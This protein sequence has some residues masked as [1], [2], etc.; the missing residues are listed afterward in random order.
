MPAAAI[1]LQRISKIGKSVSLPLPNTVTQIG[2]AYK[3]LFQPL[4][5]LLHVQRVSFWPRRLPFSVCSRPH[6]NLIPPP[7]LRH[8]QGC[9]LF[10]PACS[11]PDQLSS[12]AW[13]SRSGTA[14]RSPDSARRLRLP[15]NPL[16]Y[17][18]QKIPESCGAAAPPTPKRCRSPVS[19]REN[20]PGFS[21]RDCRYLPPDRNPVRSGRRRHG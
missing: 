19:D 13:P 2:T 6:P 7:N 4:L 3:G 21:I 15:T 10:V 1:G 20:R 16:L 18:T 11:S 5:F 8:P 17:Q 9:G 12:E 14:R